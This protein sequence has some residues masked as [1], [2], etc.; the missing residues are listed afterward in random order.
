MR[1][2]G[3]SLDDVATQKKFAKDEKLAFS[4]LSD[5]DG[6]VA[7]KYGVLAGRYAKRVTYVIDPRGTVRAVDTQVSV[8]SHGEDLAARI[9]EMQ[10]E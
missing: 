2:L 6:S 7:R 4:V 1:V 8:D 5:P 3:C 9:R 10:A